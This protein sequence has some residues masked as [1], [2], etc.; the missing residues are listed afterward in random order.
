MGTTE[1]AVKILASTQKGQSAEP[2]VIKGNNLCMKKMFNYYYIFSTYLVV[3]VQSPLNENDDI[4]FPKNKSIFNDK[5]ELKI[6]G[7]AVGMY[8]H[9]YVKVHI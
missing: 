2:L 9:T 5:I 4:Q 3:E 1:R 7:S 8:I 6:P